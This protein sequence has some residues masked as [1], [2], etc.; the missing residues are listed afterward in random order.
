MFVAWAGGEE[1]RGAEVAEGEN[2][3]EGVHSR[4]EVGG[5]G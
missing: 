2:A 3:L 1:E 5:G 4:D